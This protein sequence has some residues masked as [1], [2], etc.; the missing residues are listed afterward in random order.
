M[1]IPDLPR[2]GAIWPAAARFRHDF[3]GRERIATSEYNAEFE[4]SHLVSVYDVECPW[5]RDDD[6]FV[7]RIEAVGARDVL[8]FGCGSGRL[9]LGLA[10]RGLRVVGIDPAAASIAQARAK[11]VDARVDVRIGTEGNLP[12]DAFDAAVMTSHVAQFLVDDDEF[13]RVL[14]GLSR[15]LRAGGMLLFDHRDPAACI[16]TRWN[17]VDSRRSHRLPDGAQVDVWTEVVAVENERV[18]FVHHYDFDDG[19]RLRSTSTL[20]F[21]TEIAVRPALDASG[22]VVEAADG[23]W[24]GEPIG[25]GDGEFLVSARKAL[26]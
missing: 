17:P 24:A 16:W 20:R 10:G 2:F 11:D 14:S 13:A 3:T 4:H 22:V 15:S 8:D 1:R 9:A 19:V 12:E 21:R 7:A 26:C 6:W 5:S 25:A 18:T 23:G